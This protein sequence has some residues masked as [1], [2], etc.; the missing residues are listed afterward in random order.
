MA[1]YKWLGDEP[2]SVDVGGRLVQVQPGGIVEF[3][4]DWPHYIQTGEHGE[5]ALFDAVEAVKPATKTTK[6]EEK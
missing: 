6:N 3:P 4:A 1:K 2:A 5:P